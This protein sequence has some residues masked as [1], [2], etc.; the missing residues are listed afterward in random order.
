MSEVFDA[1]DLIGKTFKASA[2]VAKYS[3]PA[4]NASIVGYSRDGDII[5][6]LYSYL[7]PSPTY[8]RNYFMW[9]FKDGR[10]V[11]FYTRQIAGYYDT[12]FFRDQ[13]V[14]SEDEKISD[15]ELASK[16][17]YEQLIIKYGPWILGAMLA[18]T[19]IKAF[20]NKKTQ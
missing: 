9:W 18:G 20:I 15:A 8:G 12:Q 3:S 1:G 17:W 2:T 13:G 6:V 7:Q 19:A 5:G 14:K 11:D 16:P 10:G 4:D